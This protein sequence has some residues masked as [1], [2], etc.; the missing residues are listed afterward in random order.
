VMNL[1][2]IF[3]E[4]FCVEQAVN[5]IEE[6]FLNQTIHRKLQDES[7]KAWNKQKIVHALPYIVH[8][9]E[10]FQENRRDTVSIK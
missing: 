3:V 10:S 1:V 2:D 9:K 6:N 8:H 5:I 7:G 4:I